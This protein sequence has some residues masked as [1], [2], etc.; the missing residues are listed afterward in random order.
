MT[1]PE[2]SSP[3]EQDGCSTLPVTANGDQELANALSELIE[4]GAKCAEVYDIKLSSGQQLEVDTPAA[5]SLV[6]ASHSPSPAPA[7]NQDFVEDL[8][9]WHEFLK[10]APAI[11]F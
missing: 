2:S 7:A 8:F 10:R 9:D 6:S 3:A 5:S 1:A 4:I 11:D